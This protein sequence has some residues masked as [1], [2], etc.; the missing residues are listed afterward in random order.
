MGMQE[1]RIES[2]IENYSLD[3]EEASDRNRVLESAE[4][5]DG[6]YD[7]LSEISEGYL[8]EGLHSLQNLRDQLS[9]AITVLSELTWNKRPKS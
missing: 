1:F 4:I 2:L 6:V 7:A 3:R 8:E 9:L 5:G